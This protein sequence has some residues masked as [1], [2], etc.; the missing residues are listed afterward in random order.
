M[1][2]FE[3]VGVVL[4]VVRAGMLDLGVGIGARILEISDRENGSR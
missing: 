3:A 4:A 2:S 1:A